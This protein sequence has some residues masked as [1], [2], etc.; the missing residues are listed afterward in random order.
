MNR[1]LEDASHCLARIDTLENSCAELVLQIKEIG[2]AQ[3]TAPNTR[4][5]D[6]VSKLSALASFHTKL[7]WDLRC[8]TARNASQ[9]PATAHA[10]TRAAAAAAAPAAAASTDL[11]VAELA[12][13]TWT[14]KCSLATGHSTPDEIRASIAA[15]SAKKARTSGSVTATLLK[16]RGC[17]SVQELQAKRAMSL[18]NPLD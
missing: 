3:P 15:R 4:G 6:P 17:A 1:N 12:Q 18:P 8:A 9:S 13:T 11:T 16:A 2:G 7:V 10:P 5:L 14:E